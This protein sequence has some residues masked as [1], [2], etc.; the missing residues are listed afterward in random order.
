LFADFTRISQVFLNL[1][2]NSAKF[3]G[4]GGGIAFTA[5][6]KDGEL[7]ITVTDTGIGIETAMLPVIFDMFAQVD[8]ALERSHA[9]LGVG[10]TL[11]KHLVELHGGSIVAQS[12][13]LG[14]GSQFSIRLPVVAP[15][16]D[17]STAQS[18]A[19][20]SAP[21]RTSL[22]ILLADDNEDFADSLAMLLGA[23]GHE[24][25]VEHDGLRAADAAAEFKPEFAF[26]DI[27][28]PKLNGYELA[29]RLREG[30]ATCQTVLIAVTG[31]GQPDDRRRSR[32]AG[33]VHHLVKPVEFASI[34]QILS[35]AASP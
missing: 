30:P 19:G 33:F 29:H 8:R 10:L 27:G 31:W 35:N 20:A 14:R 1:L 32:E 3:T 5:Q 4:V 12:E 17:A 22:R 6:L 28:L 18:A 21:A 16:G 24:V 2:N 26:L 34:Q 15:S 23:L 7:V 9:G 11:V 25:R 13:G